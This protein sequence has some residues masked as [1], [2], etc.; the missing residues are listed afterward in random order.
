[1]RVGSLTSQLAN[2]LGRPVNDA[3]GL[4]GVYD[5]TLHYRREEAAADSGENA[6]APSVF[7]AVQEQ[8]GLKPVPGNGAD[9]GGG[10]GTKAGSELR[11]RR[12]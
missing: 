3:T 1:V 7:S 12:Q 11:V 2:A 4:T 6:D 10:C 9:A 5:I 8:L